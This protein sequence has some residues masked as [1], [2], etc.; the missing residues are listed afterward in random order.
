MHPYLYLYNLKK[1]PITAL[2]SMM[3]FL[4]LCDYQKLKIL[5]LIKLAIF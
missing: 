1:T 3:S 5:N 2:K 4:N